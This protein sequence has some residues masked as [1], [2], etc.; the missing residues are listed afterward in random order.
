MDS[1]LQK[2]LKIMEI[3][4]GNICDHCLGRKFSNDIEGPGNPLRGEKIRKIILQEDITVSKDSKCAVCND[5]F[6]NINEELV[7]NIAQKIKDLRLEFDGFVV[8]SKLVKEVVERDQSLSQ[9]MELEVESIKKEVNRE[10]GKL[11]E[12]GLHKEADFDNPHLVIMVDFKK[13]T[14]SVRIQINPLFLEGRYRKLIRGI[15]QTKWP[16]RKCKGRGCEE[17]GFTGKMYTESVEELISPRVLE[18]TQGRSSKFHG[19]G[20][21]DID[22]RML[23]TG[24][25][26]VL[27]IKEPRHR[28]IDLKKLTL[29]INQEAG[30]KV[31]VLQLKYSEKARKASIKTSSPDTFKTYQAQVE[32]EE[33]FHAEKL[34]KLQ[35]M[36]IINQRTPLRVSHRRADKVRIRE[37]KSIKAKI[38]SPQHIELIIKGQGGLYIKELIS[39]D[40]ERTSPNISEVLGTPARCVQLDVLEVQG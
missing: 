32:L 34:E 40:N 33:P 35:S 28:T 14:P 10:L 38:I 1:K 15:P 21:E 26:F 9:K 36:N 30:G 24:R 19:A 22:V 5:L 27:E 7:K 23:G 31:E 11:L 16:C 29:E 39:G 37:I 13:E 3:T 20:R 4:K 8:G 6:F 25:P 2:A 12:K 18:I 17:C